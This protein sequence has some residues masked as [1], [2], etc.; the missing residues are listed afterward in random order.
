MSHTDDRGI[1]SEASQAAYGVAMTSRLLKITGLFC[2][3]SS[4]L[5]G[6]FAKETCDFKEPTSHSHPISSIFVLLST[7][8][9]PLADASLSLPLSL[10][11]SLSLPLS[12]PFSFVL[13]PSLSIFLSLSLSLSPF[14]S[15]SLYFS[16][17]LSLSL[18]LLQCE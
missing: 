17:S 14:L 5:Q 13:F 8:L 18:S 3:K 1:Q 10:S 16:L 12:L 4:L 2:R 15:L 7:Y 11:I 6:S 9:S